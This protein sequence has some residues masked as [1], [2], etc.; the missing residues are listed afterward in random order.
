[1]GKS[2]KR[3]ALVITE[4]RMVIN[5]QLVTIDPMEHGLPDRCKLLLAEMLT[6]C[7]FELVKPDDREEQTNEPISLHRKWPSG[8]G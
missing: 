5:G 8:R 7:K 2:K 4:H 6:G 3:P 1:M